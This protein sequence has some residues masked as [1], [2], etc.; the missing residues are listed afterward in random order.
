VHLGQD[1]NA[2]Y[3]QA[4]ENGTFEL[5]VNATGDILPLP[6]S[7]SVLAPADPGMMVALAPFPWW[8]LIAAVVL[9]AVSRER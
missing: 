3:A 8:L 4:Q 7:P 6:V 5:S 9:I 2:N 1:V